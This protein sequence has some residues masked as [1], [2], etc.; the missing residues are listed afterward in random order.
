MQE[1]ALSISRVAP[2]CVPSRV[3]RGQMLNLCTGTRAAAET[4]ARSCFQSM[5]ATLDCEIAFFRK[6]R[7]RIANRHRE[8]TRQSVTWWLES[9]DLPLERREP[10]A[11]ACIEEKVLTWFISPVEEN[12]T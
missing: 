11:S 10:F 5:L 4:Y 1:T 7:D 6:R 8:M 3:H 12:G 2:P 9:L